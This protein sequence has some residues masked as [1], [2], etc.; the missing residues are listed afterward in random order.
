M[1]KNYFKT[2]WRNLLKNKTSSF[3]NISGLAVGMSVAMLI[4]IWIWDEL[5]FDKYHQNYSR[6]VQVMQKE[7]FLGATKVWNHLPYLLVNELKTGYKS[8]FKHIVAVTESEGYS[9]SAG[10][11][12]IAKAGLFV[13]ASAPEMF[14]LKMEKGSW[15]CL[16]DPHSILLSA[17]AAKALFGNGDPMGKLVN[18]RNV[19]DANINLSVKVTGVYE[20]LPQNTP[21]AEV[22]YFLPWDLYA[23]N[24][25]G[26]ANYGW[27]DHRFSIYAELQPGAD[28]DK[29]AARIKD[30]ELN[31]I[32]GLDNSKAEVAANPQLFLHPMAKWHLYS[33]FKDGV[34]DHGPIQFVWLVG[35]IGGFVLLLACINF[36]NLSTARAG[37]RAKEVGIRKV[38]GSLRGQLVNQFLSESLLVVLFAFA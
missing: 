21:L 8:D 3:I 9:L 23:S 22:R 29:V 6:I 17:S 7:K 20:D 31:V 11:T 30:A 15:N 14:T 27:E 28:F 12:K 10:E 24:N 36:M 25:S 5:S 1:L 18:L 35:I 13:E 37:Q 26:I 33:D 16:Q 34:A 4:G 32:K 38:M 19:W 2:A